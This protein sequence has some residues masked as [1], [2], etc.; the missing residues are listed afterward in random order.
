[1]TASIAA[2]AYLLPV[3]QGL[4]DGASPSGPSAVTPERGATA[5]TAAASPVA[6]AAVTP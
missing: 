1:M 5:A 3:D 4:F 6:P 2:Q